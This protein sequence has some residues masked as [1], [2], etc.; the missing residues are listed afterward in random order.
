MLEDR[1]EDMLELSFYQCFFF[2]ILTNT[3]FKHVTIV[4]SKCMRLHLM[5]LIFIGLLIFSVCVRI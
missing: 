5:L 1:L 2:H 4:D 3:K